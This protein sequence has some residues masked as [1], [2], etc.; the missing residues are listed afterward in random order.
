MKMIQFEGFTPAEPSGDPL[1][2]ESSLNRRSATWENIKWS[3]KPPKWISDL[4]DQARLRV[5]PMRQQLFYYAPEFGKP[6]PVEP[7][8]WLIN[9]GGEVL[10]VVDNSTLEAVRKAL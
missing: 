7:G 5:D 9:R 8:A 1:E 10:R 3:G 4:A 6:I 2:T